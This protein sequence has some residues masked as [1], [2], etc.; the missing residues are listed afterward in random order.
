MVFDQHAQ[1]LYD[2]TGFSEGP[3]L[4]IAEDNK[5]TDKLSHRKLDRYNDNNKNGNKN[6]DNTN[7]IVMYI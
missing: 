7:T 6:N 3:A 1:R 2:F 5:I 4:F